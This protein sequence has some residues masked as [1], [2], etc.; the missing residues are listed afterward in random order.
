MLLADAHAYRDRDS[1][2]MLRMSMPSFKLLL[3]GARGR[4]HGIAREG[5]RPVKS[6]TAAASGDLANGESHRHA[7]PGNG[8]RPSVKP[9]YRIGVTCRLTVRELRALRARLL[10]GLGL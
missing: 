1:A 5:G 7:E 8:G 9:T 2:A 6:G 10:E 3:H 4:L